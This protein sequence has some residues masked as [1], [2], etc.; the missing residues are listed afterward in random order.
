MLSVSRPAPLVDKEERQRRIWKVVAA[1]PEGCVASYGQVAELAG[2]ARGARL[3]T[4]ALSAA[5]KDLQL[6]W[7]R[8]V[9]AAGRIAIPKAS[10]GHA[11][12]RRL[13]M[14]EGVLFSGDRINLKRFRWQ[15]TLDEILWRLG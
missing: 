9:N 13:L 11:R 8:V 7:Y 6:P 5:P 10:P 15:P 14:A 4:P 2:F 1:I 12:Q 3:V